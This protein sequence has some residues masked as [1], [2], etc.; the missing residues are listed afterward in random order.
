[1]RKI[2]TLAVL[3]AA[4]SSCFK[5][6]APNAECDI[7]TAEVVVDDWAAFFYNESDTRATITKDYASSEI[8]FQNVLDAADLTAL[9]PI[10]TIS[11]GATIV[12]ASGTVRDFSQEGQTYVVTSASG[13][14][15]REYTVR[16]VYPQSEKAW[17]FEEFAL[18][19]DGKYYEWAGDWATANPGFSVANGGT[20]PELYPSVPDPNGVRGYCVKLTTT[21]TG[22][23][24]A[25]VKKPLA[26]GNLFLGAFDLSKA[27]TNTLES[28]LFGIPYNLKPVRFRGYYKFAAGSQITDADGNNV[29]GV[30]RPAIYARLYRNHDAD[31]NAISLNG[32]N[33]ATST[34]IICRAEVE[35]QESSDWVYFD[36]P[37]VYDGS[38]DDLDLDLLDR[39][40]YSLAVTCASSK[41]GA[42]YEG[43]IGS[44][45][46]V[47][48]L[49]IFVEGDSD[50]DPAA[51]G[52]DEGDAD[53]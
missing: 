45:L 22:V 27:L 20:D 39:W 43:A 42:Q 30:D 37:F 23:W 6:E 47:D 32:E 15:Q 12:P 2:I 36:I 13:K 24:G 7:L 1:M 5:D 29:A 51:E 53:I 31:G 35:T 19:D 46:Y 21:S 38:E 52:S 25:L 40:G 50:D 14:W 48:E 34:L 41:N 44:T 8:R 3:C 16:F 17:S 4:L 28:T 49:S 18:T 10:F 26:A 9:A 33:V 11:E